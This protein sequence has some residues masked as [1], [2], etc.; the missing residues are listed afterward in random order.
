MNFKEALELLNRG[1]P[2]KRKEWKGYWIKKDNNIIIHLK[3]GED[4][5]IRDTDDIFFTLS[6]T[7][8]SDW[9]IATTDN[10][11]RLVTDNA[12]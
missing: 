11:P 3:E 6:H 1:V 10:C 9:E 8:E 4:L 5:D 12:K 7:V 2:V